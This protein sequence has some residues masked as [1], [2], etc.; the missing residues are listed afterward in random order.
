[1]QQKAAPASF[2]LLRRLLLVARS[3]EF[4]AD[5]FELNYGSVSTFGVPRWAVRVARPQVAVG[6][7][8]DF[9]CIGH[10][11]WHAELDKFFGFRVEPVERIAVRTADPNEA[12][13]IDV[14]RIGDL[15]LRIREIVNFPFFGL[16]IE[17]AEHT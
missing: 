15:V 16:W 6:V 10:A 11:R 1:M 14:Q 13:R 8:F 17:A 4:V 9:T 12:L 2:I 7:E 5:D 3:L